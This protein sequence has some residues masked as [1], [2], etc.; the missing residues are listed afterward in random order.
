MIWSSTM[1]CMFYLYWEISI[2]SWQ[3]IIFF[4]YMLM[5]FFDNFA[6]NSSSFGQCG[7]FVCYFWILLWGHTCEFAVQSLRGSSIREKYALAL[8][9]LKTG[10]PVVWFWLSWIRILW[11]WWMVGILAFQRCWTYP[12]SITFRGVFKI[13]PADFLYF[14]LYSLSGYI[15][16]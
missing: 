6:G 3:V 2:S 9:G 12:A 1:Y 4:S 14:L 11:S 8:R 7:F 5:L 10:I 13:C 15:I 16:Y